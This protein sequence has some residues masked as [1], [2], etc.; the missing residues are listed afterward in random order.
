MK[1]ISIKYYSDCM[2]IVFQKICAICNLWCFIFCKSSNC[3][4]ALYSLIHLFISSLC[5]KV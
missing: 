5:I 1:I 2:Q 3:V 4:F